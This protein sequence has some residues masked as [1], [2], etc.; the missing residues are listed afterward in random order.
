MSDED[1]H[2]AVYCPLCN[3]KVKY[4]YPPGGGLN[5]RDEAILQALTAHYYREYHPR[6]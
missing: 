4:Q 5:A 3:A 1:T 2:A 6:P